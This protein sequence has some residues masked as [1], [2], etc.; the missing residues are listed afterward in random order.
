MFWETKRNN[1]HLSKMVYLIKAR[2][3]G[4]SPRRITPQVSPHLHSHR[5]IH[6]TTDMIFRAERQCHAAWHRFFE[7]SDSVQLGIS[8]IPRQ[9]NCGIPVPDGEGR[10][11]IIHPWHSQI[12]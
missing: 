10:E 6:T 5:T 7:L 12:D 3:L 8:F 2:A 1:E 11:T 9:K 4:S